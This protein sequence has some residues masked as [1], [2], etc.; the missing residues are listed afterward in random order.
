MIESRSIRVIRRLNGAIHAELIIAVKN[1]DEFEW[2]KP[3]ANEIRDISGKPWAM[4]DGHR[5]DLT[6]H[7]VEVMR[8][9]MEEML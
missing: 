9:L 5:R 2:S 3:H 4:V 8:N 6:P 7:Q 1:D